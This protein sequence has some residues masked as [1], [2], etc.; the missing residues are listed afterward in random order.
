M[1]VQTT[2]PLPHLGEDPAEPE[3]EERGPHRRCIV[4]R[5]TGERGRMIRFVLGPDRQIVPDLAA[6]L[7]G[8]GM[9]LSARA[10]VVETARAKGAFARAARGPVN[11]PADL[12]DMLVAGLRRR[13]V[14]QLGLARRAGQA[15]SGFAKAR[16]WVT[17]GRAA[18]VV[19]ADDGSVDERARLVSGARSIWIAW[20]LPAAALGAVFGRD[21]AVHVAVAPG[22]LAAALHNEIERLSGMSGQALVKQAGE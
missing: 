20:P 15:V 12:R 19:Q 10:D 13:V 5:E 17:L 1:G 7:P 14:D 3:D 18:G 22:R 16:E 21:H 2:D 6:K 9:W 4:T 8:R 11:L